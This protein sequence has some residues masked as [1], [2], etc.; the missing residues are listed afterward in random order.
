LIWS[1]QKLKEM[2]EDHIGSQCLQQI[3]VL[4]NTT[5]TTTT[6]AAATTITTTKN[7]NNNNIDPK[8]EPCV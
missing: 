4:V 6:T 8:N 3:A 7:N 1:G 2:V 5:T